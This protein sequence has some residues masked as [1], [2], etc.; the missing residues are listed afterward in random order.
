MNKMQRSG[1]KTAN[2]MECATAY[3]FHVIGIEEILRNIV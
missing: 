1:G 2:S 3:G